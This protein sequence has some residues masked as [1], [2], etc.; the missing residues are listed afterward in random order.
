M[1]A[2]CKIVRKRAVCGEK[3][4]G[5]AAYNLKE[6]CMLKEKGPKRE[7]KPTAAER[8]LKKVQEL[9][10]FNQRELL[11]LKARQEK[12]VHHIKPDT[13]VLPRPGYDHRVIRIYIK[14]AKDSQD[15]TVR[16]RIREAVDDFNARRGNRPELKFDYTIERLVII[17]AMNH[18]LMASM[19]LEK[20]L[21]Q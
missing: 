9:F 3:P 17:G 10:D 11:R 1:Q 20:A 14:K 12:V 21:T 18:Y 4:G 15:K 7:K 5:H 19:D 2:I 13:D 8:K 16:A 6:S